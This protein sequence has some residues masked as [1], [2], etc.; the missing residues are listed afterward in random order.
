[1]SVIVK[2]RKTGERF[3]FLGFGRSLFDCGVLASDRDGTLQ[4]LPLPI[5]WGNVITD[6]KV[7]NVDGQ[8]PGEL[9]EAARQAEV[10]EI[11]DSAQ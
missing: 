11:Q 9:I 2:S 6:L 8:S 7:E 3:V 10:Q 1:M 4:Y 5:R